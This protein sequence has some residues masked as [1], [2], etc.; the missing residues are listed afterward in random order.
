MNHLYLVSESN[1]YFF[2]V[3]FHRQICFLISLLLIALSVNGQNSYVFHHLKTG[4][5]LSNS[6]V[7][8][9]L[10]DHKGFLWIGTESGLNCY[11]GYNFKVYRARPA[12]PNAMWI[13]DVWT[14]QEDGMGYIWIGAS[15]AYMV[16]HHDKDCFI[17]DTHSFLRQ[18]GIRVEGRFRVHVDKKKDLWVLQGQNVF[19][20]DVKQ[21][22]L[23]TFVVSDFPEEPVEMSISDDGDGLYVLLNSATLWKIEKRKGIKK[24]ENFADLQK[25]YSL[26]NHKNIYVD[27]HRGIWIYSYMNDCIFY[28]K[29]AQAK[30]SEITLSSVVATHS[31]AVRSI[32]DDTSGN[33]WIGTD[34]KG[35]FVYDYVNDSQTNLL[36]TPSSYTSLASDRINT[37]YRDDSGVIWLGHF[38]K[39]ISYYHDSFY[40]FISSQQQEYGDIS[41]LLED[42]A[43]NIWFGT[44]GNGLYIK[45]KNANFAIRKLPI[46]NIAIVS[47]LEDSKGRIWIG[48]YQHGLFCYD[49]GRIRHFTKENGKLPYNGVLALKEDRYGNLWIGNVTETLFSFHP[50]TETFT[51]YLLPDGYSIC[52]LNLFYD[53]GDKLYIGTTYG[54]C[55][56][57]IVT[58]KTEM[59][60]GNSRGTQQFNEQFISNVFK[61]DRDILWLGHKQGL[62]GWDLKTDS[63]YWFDVTNGLCDNLVRSLV[64]DNHHNMWIATSNGLSTLV[65]EDARKDMHFNF[66]NFSTKDGLRDNYFNAYSIC[67]LSNGDILLGGTDGYTLVNPNKLI[68]KNQPLANV[69]FTSLSIGNQK[70]EVDS[71][72]NGRKLLEHTIDNVSS[73]TLCYDDNL[74]S[75][76]FFTGNL[77]NADKIKY[78]YKL[79]GLDTQWYYTSENRITFTTL[80]PG[81][82]KLLIKANNGNGV[83]N[84][85]PAQLNIIVSPP[86][87][88][89]GWAITLYILA[90]IGIIIYVIYYVRRHHNRKLEQQRLQ[91]EQEQRMQLNEMKLKFFTNISHDLRTPLTLIISPLQMMMDE[92]TDSG[93]HKKL[94]TIY[95]NAQQLLGLINSLLDFRKLD[96]GAEALHCKSGDI[97]NY[98]RE[99]CD[100]FQDYAAERSFNFN[101]LCEIDNYNMS[102]DPVKIQKIMNNLLSNA[103]KYT[104][105][106]GDIFVHL[107]TENENVCI[108]VADNGSGISDADKKYIFERFF[109]TSQL[110]EK[111]GSGIGLHIVY[112]YVRLHK[113]TI[114]VTDN[115]PNGSVFT[116]KLPTVISEEEEQTLSGKSLS[117]KPESRVNAHALRDRHKLL[118]VDDNKDFCDFMFDSL[119]AYYKV[120]IAH[121]GVEA[122]KILAENDINIVVSDVMMPVMNGTELCRQIKTNIQ[123]SHIPVLLLTARTA[124]ECK[125]EG[126]KQGAD[127]YIIKPFNFNL[128][129]MRIDKFIEW[130]ERCHREFSQK[131]EVTPSEI[132][133]TPLDEQLIAKA[134]KLV[135]EHISDPN[136]SVEMLGEMLGLS[137][138]HLYKKLICITGK[139]PAEFIRTIRLKRGKQLLEKS[140]KQISE[141]AYEVGFNS[142]KRFTLN[143][144]NEFGM[145]PFDYIRSIK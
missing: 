2:M 141:I 106:G 25:Q 53:Q 100:S 10:K 116:I 57:D 56:M 84:D 91:I 101:F 132:T 124:E 72:Y 27:H 5:G 87:Y 3:R 78:A 105:D 126:Y 142:P 135:E 33:V 96:V 95:K 45:E 83:W 122:L 9:I 43:G 76:E 90:V 39:G 67:K 138:S 111:T 80:P 54:L 120:L 62:T 42:K 79:E 71:F 26:K 23:K 89:C 12:T 73:L 1:T 121:N 137:R 139:G 75:F 8:A 17:T 24:L 64:E 58:K 69:H 99:V 112:E 82:Y 115:I 32:L 133:I 61:D 29:N 50:E 117:S 85:Q 109:Q 35:V 94:Q 36:N 59:R 19:Y 102:F 49:N 107:Y 125:I 6:N 14:L 145:S 77:L 18:F 41:S 51:S 44:D 37:I 20:Y 92:I 97:V 65:I 15:T 47:L 130:T 31:N 74:I 30:W 140:Q 110:Q 129:K 66:K 21:A 7:E 88:L 63:L 70:I 131:L 48:S 98:V 136:F 86:V 4:S 128:L 55:V 38:K 93:M 28:Q 13:D 40:E 127:D 52:A 144:K 118:F 11:D 68:K 123:W 134:I 22:A 60:F 108:S 81:N 113:G 34:H 103:F 16:Y 104:P 119:S 46:P 143:F 114:S